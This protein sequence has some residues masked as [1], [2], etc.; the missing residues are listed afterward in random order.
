MEKTESDL[1]RDAPPTLTTEEE[2]ESSESVEAIDP[3]DDGLFQMLNA[4]VR[5]TAAM[6]PKKR[7]K[8]HHHHHHNTKPIS[9]HRRNIKSRPQ[10][11]P[12]IPELPLN[13]EGVTT[14]KSETRKGRNAIGRSRSGSNGKHGMSE[15]D[16]LNTSQTSST[17]TNKSHRTHTPGT[18]KKS[19]SRSRSQPRERHLHR[20]DRTRHQEGGERRRSSSLTRKESLPSDQSDHCTTQLS[21]PPRSTKVANPPI[22]GEQDEVADNEEVVDH[23][24]L[25][26]SNNL[27]TDVCEGD[28]QQ[29]DEIAK[30]SSGKG[31]VAMMSKGAQACANRVAFAATH[32]KKELEKVVGMVKG[33]TQATGRAVTHPK[34]D[35]QETNDD[36]INK[37]E[38]EKPDKERAT[39]NSEGSCLELKEEA[40]MNT[41]NHDSSNCLKD[42]ARRQRQ[43]VRPGNG[44]LK[45]PTRSPHADGRSDRSELT[46]SE[47]S[48]RGENDTP[49]RPAVRMTVRERRH[50]AAQL[51][52]ASKPDS[53]PAKSEARARHATSPTSLSPKKAAAPSRRGLDPKQSS[54]SQDSESRSVDCEKKVQQTSEV[55]PEENEA[56]W[57]KARSSR[58][59]DIMSFAKKSDGN[60]NTQRTEFSTWERGNGDQLS[61]A[62]QDPV[63]GIKLG[64]SEAIP[65]GNERKTILTAGAKVAKVAIGVT[66]LGAREAINAITN[67]KKEIEK[68]MRVSNK[69]AKKTARAASNPKVAVQKM[70]SMTQQISMN[71]VREATEVTKGTLQLGR[72]TVQGTV[73]YVSGL[74]LEDGEQKSATR[75]KDEAEYNCQAL[76]SRKVNASLL[77]RVTRVVDTADETKSHGVPPRQRDHRRDREL[78]EARPGMPEKMPSRL[79]QNAT[80]KPSSSWET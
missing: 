6:S 56:D 20:R 59:D 52:N 9:P 4:S 57:L 10:P 25:L 60:K 44:E 34:E 54:H 17:S 19:T 53:L 75:S 12:E 31:V 30:P 78:R 3:S 1:V 23:E 71:V 74:L 47:H 28:E 7:N 16:D 61:S 45:S 24:V 2:E 48:A 35:V 43:R 76:E 50:R 66:A 29:Q 22:R 58:Q 40:G 27:L 26:P 14:P 36:G 77:D 51:R 68:V 49:S 38:G 46:V 80:G 13:S 55:Q 8:N 42:T 15:N 5:P 62:L 70:A 69:A 64:G 67:P 65:E 79:V 33:A 37:D 73:G 11:S 21:R 32:P 39:E 72:E 63:V 41:S 18:S